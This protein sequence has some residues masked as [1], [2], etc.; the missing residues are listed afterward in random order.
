MRRSILL[1]L[2]NFS[3][4]I[5]PLIAQTEKQVRWGEILRQPTSWYGSDEAQRIADNVLLYQHENGGWYK[6]ID[7]AQTLSEEEQKEILKAKTEPSGTTIDNGATFTQLRFLALVYDATKEK[8]YQSAFLRGIDYL[9]AAQYENGG[10]PQYYPIR[11]GYYEHITYN[12]GAMIGV[13]SLLWDVSE[14]NGPYDFVKVSIRKKAKAAV[15]KGLEIILDTQVVLDGELTIWC[16]Q[17]YKDSLEPAKA[18]AFEL[19]SLSGAESVGIL[20]YLMKIPDPNERVKKSISSAVAWLEEHKIEGKRIIK[21]EDDRL[22]KGYDLQVI[23]DPEGRPLWARFYELNTQKPIFVG[24]DS[25]IKYDLSEI[26]YERRVGYS[27]LGNYAERVLD[28]D[29]PE[30]KSKW[31][32]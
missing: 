4:L 26:E 25:Q 24:R 27:Y 9:L 20:K 5:Q 3:L 30:W 18:R 32:D 12:D 7:M 6:N 10:W 11:K 16:A 1:L 22:E 15:D 19:A 29:Y 8:K 23:E 2:I 14:G 21:V 28:K 31:I 13:M 17:H